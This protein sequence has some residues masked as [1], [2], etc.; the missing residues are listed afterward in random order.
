MIAA[1]TETGHVTRRAEAAHHHQQVVLLVE[2]DP[3]VMRI[4]S[5]LLSNG[6]YRVV[7]AYG[8]EDAV[9]KLERHPVDA[10][11]TDLAMPRLSGVH[12]I[13]YLKRNVE[14]AHVPVVAVTAFTWDP[15]GRTA[16]ELG[17]DGFV[18][19]PVDRRLLLETVRRVL[20]RH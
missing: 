8:V 11:L 5:Y 10:V 6:G 4:L 1:A 15:L 7:Q 19:K 18:S 13:E 12:L 3:H 16:A 2:D 17:V 14:T 9:R 20:D